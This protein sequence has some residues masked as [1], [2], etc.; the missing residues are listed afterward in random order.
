M[1]DREIRRWLGS[2]LAGEVSLADF[3]NWFM[4]ATWDVHR[5]DNPLAVA[6]A[7]EIKLRLAE[8]SNGHWTEEEFRSQIH[9]FA[10]PWKREVVI[11]T[12]GSSSIT[13]TTMAAPYPLRI[14]GRSSAAVP[15]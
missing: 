3:G 15:A 5:S 10:P 12:G 6:L 7:V 11:A 13:T 14:A 1:M 9:Q 2:Y 8:L 4:A